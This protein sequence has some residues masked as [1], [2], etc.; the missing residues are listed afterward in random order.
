VEVVFTV[1]MIQIMVICVKITR[2]ND[3]NEYIAYIKRY[4]RI[5]ILKPEQANKLKLCREVG[6][7]YGLTDADMDSIDWSAI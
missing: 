2:K 3:M 4:C 7:Q 6:Y 5:L 1:A